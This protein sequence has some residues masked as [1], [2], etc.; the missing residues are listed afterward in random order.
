M[1]G[2][3]KRFKKKHFNTIKPLIKIDK[4][5]IFEESIS[6]LP[7]AKKKFG[8]VNK[9]IFQKYNLLKKIFIENKIEDFQLKKHSLGQSDTCYKL[10]NTINHNDDVMI[11]S[12]DY[13]MKYS[14]KKLMKKMSMADVLIFTYKLKSTIVENYKHFAYCEVKKDQVLSIKEKKIISPTPENDQMIIGTFWFKKYKDF[15]HAHESGVI[16]KNFIN[17]EIYVANNINYLIKKKK[18]VKIFEVSE[19]KNLGDFFSYQMYIY[20]KNYFSKT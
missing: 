19:W 11:H 8:V 1:A 18:K 4:K 12:C 3:G 14:K 17:N 9:M 20:W 10:K 16:N 7:K 5:C 6:N 15:L 13:V 2:L